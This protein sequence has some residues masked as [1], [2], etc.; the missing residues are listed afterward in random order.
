MTQRREEENR[1]Y[2]EYMNKLEGY[3]S[4]AEQEE[5]AF[6]RSRMALSVGD[7]DG[8]GFES[9]TEDA[10]GTTAGIEDVIDETGDGKKSTALQQS[11]TPETSDIGAIEKPSLADSTSA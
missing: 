5:D 8:N 2:H 9:M 3:L 1:Q 4:Q 6:N 10:S 11:V 7:T